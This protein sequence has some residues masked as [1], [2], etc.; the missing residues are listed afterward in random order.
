MLVV[1]LELWPGGDEAKKRVI[2]SATIANVGGDDRHGTYQAT[3]VT[4]GISFETRVEDHPREDGAWALVAR[5]L[6]A[7]TWHWGL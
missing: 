7:K 2:G 6:A 1:K 3:V 4:D 5:V